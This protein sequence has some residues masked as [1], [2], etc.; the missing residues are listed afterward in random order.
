LLVP[1]WPEA[2]EL[3]DLP[4]ELYAQVSEAVRRFSQWM[5]TWPGVEKVNVG[6]I[7]NQV[8]QLHLHVVGR[9]SQDPAWP[10]VVWSHG[11]K[12]PY[13]EVE[14]AEHVARIKEWLASA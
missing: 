2:R 1:E 10:G 8:S 11:E 14:L 4:A 13:S 3:H 12:T 6:A 9:H 5:S 7:G